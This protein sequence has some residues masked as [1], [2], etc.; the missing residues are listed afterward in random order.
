MCSALCVCVHACAVGGGCVSTC[1]SLLAHDLVGSL[2][3]RRQ[4]SH[5][6]YFQSLCAFELRHLSIDA[7]ESEPIARGWQKFYAACQMLVSGP[8]TVEQNIPI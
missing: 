6:F 1:L 7:E 5:V 4:F 3:R 8:D 2:V